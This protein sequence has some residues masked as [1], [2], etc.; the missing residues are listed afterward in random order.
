MFPSLPV[1]PQALS[2]Y[3]GHSALILTGSSLLANNKL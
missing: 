3:E 1:I 2:I